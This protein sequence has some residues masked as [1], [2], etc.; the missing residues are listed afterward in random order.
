MKINGQEIILQGTINMTNV[1][2]GNV[3]PFHLVKSDLPWHTV[4]SVIA[5]FYFF[6]GSHKY[7]GL[8]IRNI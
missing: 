7:C 4:A 6:L 8:E 3:Q 5:A 1:T 2:G